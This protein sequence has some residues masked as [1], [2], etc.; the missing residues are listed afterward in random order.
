MGVS[1]R[2]LQIANW[3]RRLAEFEILL[4][5]HYGTLWLPVGF[6]KLPLS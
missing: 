2:V 3:N 4:T 5:A 1:G 6:P